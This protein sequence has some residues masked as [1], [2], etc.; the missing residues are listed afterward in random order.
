MNI[1][2]SV[3]A[4]A[5][6]GGL[7]N[8]EAALK[9]DSAVEF[10]QE[11]RSRE[12]E[13]KRQQSVKELVHNN[14]LTDPFEIVPNFGEA[15]QSAQIKALETRLSKIESAIVECDSDGGWGAAKVLRGIHPK[16]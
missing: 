4:N 3:F 13:K 14:N 9:A 11:W 5:C 6:A 2:E 12:P 1:W 16:G 8:E 7:S 10:A 15:I